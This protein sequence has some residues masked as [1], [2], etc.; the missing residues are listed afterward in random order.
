M[1]INGRPS[2][3]K[4][5]RK[6]CLGWP[7]WRLRMV[8]HDFLKWSR[9]QEVQ[10]SIQAK[11]NAASEARSRLKAQEE[12]TSIDLNTKAKE[13]EEE[14]QAIREKLKEKG[15]SDEEALH[16]Q[17]VVDHRLKTITEFEKILTSY[18]HEMDLIEKASLASTPK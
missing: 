10:A 3:L 18:K 13:C 2:P 14:D 15:V 6:I 5:L 4:S 1:G 17:L 8:C 12:K 9:A 11:P 7:T 16:Y